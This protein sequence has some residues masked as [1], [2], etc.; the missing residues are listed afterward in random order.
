MTRVHPPARPCS[1]DEAVAT[2]NNIK[3][4]KGK[5]AAYDLRPLGR[6]S[7]QH[8]RIIKIDENT[9]ALWPSSHWWCDTKDF[10]KEDARIRAAVLWQRTAEGDF[11]HVRNSWFNS[12]N[13]SHYRFLNEVLPHGLTFA[14]QSS[15]QYIIPHFALKKHYLP[16]DEWFGGSYAKHI[17]GDP[18]KPNV[19]DNSPLTPELVYKHKGGNKF[20]L[21]SKEYVVPKKAVNL[22]LKTALTPSIRAFKEWALIMAPMLN[23]K[24]YWVWSEKDNSSYRM[25]SEAHSAQ[26]RTDEQLLRDWMESNGYGKVY[27]INHVTPIIIRQIVENDAHPL[28]VVLAKYVLDDCGYT[29]LADE[30]RRGVY[31]E[32]E[33]RAKLGTT[34]NYYMNR[35]LGLVEEK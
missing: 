10:D 29:R 18:N 22:E 11:V 14:T 3:P 12:S 2:Y 20:D 30:I 23:L 33:A 21:V 4:S 28:R 13:I 25:A 26:K 32:R 35:I 16:H 19:V 6:R 31:N 8:E 17:S 24:P 9:Y 34:F 5:Y 15:K 27:V 7:N 1:F